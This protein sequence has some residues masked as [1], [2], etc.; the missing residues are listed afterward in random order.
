M[1]LNL[2]FAHKLVEGVLAGLGEAPVRV[3]LRGHLHQTVDRLA[4]LAAV[5]AELLDVVQAVTDK[6]KGVMI[7]LYSLLPTIH[8]SQTFLHS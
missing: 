4:V 3:L 5:G 7:Y 1:Q 2:N 8:Y 6:M